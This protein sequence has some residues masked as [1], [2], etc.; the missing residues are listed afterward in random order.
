MVDA[1]I[2]AYIHAWRSNDPAAIASLF[3]EDATYAYNP[4]DAPLKGREAIVADWLR[5]PDEPDSWQADYR[6]MLTQGNRA[7]V[8]GLTRYANGKT[9]S[10]LFVIDFDN[11]GR[12]RAFTEWYMRH[13]KPK[14]RD[15]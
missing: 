9:Y 13:P 8:T 4:W 14:P 6:P 5:E 10:N 12:C 3:A 11:E 2:E 15:G 7:M 1:W